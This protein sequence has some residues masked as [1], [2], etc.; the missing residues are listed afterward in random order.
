MADI[1]HTFGQDIDF[2]PGG[3]VA[4][5]DGMDLDK[6]R[7]LRRLLTN[8]G[9]YIWHGQ[10]GAGLARFLGQPASV[11]SIS[12]VAR[13]QIFKEA[14]V[15]RNPSPSISVSRNDTGGVVL[16]IQYVDQE[17]KTTVTLTA[18]VGGV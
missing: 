7:I 2:D 5:S 10:Y 9:E 17:T 4:T 11:Q 3:D 6:E 14:S 13:G 15:A 1:S 12:S 8:P 16:S 18:P